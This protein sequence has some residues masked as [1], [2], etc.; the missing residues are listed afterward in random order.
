LINQTPGA[1]IKTPVL[2]GKLPPVKLLPKNKEVEVV[3]PS[4]P[5]LVVGAAPN[6]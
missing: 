5:E 6:V 1:G 3:Y 2:S 4:C